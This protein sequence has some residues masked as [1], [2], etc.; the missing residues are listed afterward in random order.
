MVIFI[1]AHVP[2]VAL[3]AWARGNNLLIPVALSFALSGAVLL[4]W[5]ANRQALSTRLTIAA[6]LIGQVSLLVYG[7]AGHPW[8]ADMHMYYFAA[9]AVLAVFCDGRVVVMGATVTALHHLILNFVFPAAV[10]SGGSDLARVLLHAVL[11]VMETGAL[12]WLCL[13][14]GKAVALSS[15][16]LKTLE[17]KTQAEAAQADRLREQEEAQ[18]TKLRTQRLALAE[19]FEA[20]IGQVTRRLADS[21]TVMQKSATTLA[22]A[23]SQVADAS[24]DVTQSSR[25]ANDGALAAA[26]AT[27]QLHQ[28]INE[29]GSKI[30]ATAG[31]AQ[32]AVL[33]AEK[34]GERVQHLA[35]AADRIGQVI[36]LIQDIAA[37]TNLLAL[38]ATI[39]A[40]RA[41]DAGK[42]FAV[43]AAEV[44]QL[45]TQTARATE[46]IQTQVTA[47]Q[48]ETDQAVEAIV[49]IGEAITDI[50]GLAGSVAAAVHQQDSV[51]GDLAGRVRIVA[52]E[53]TAASGA[54]GTISGDT[55]AAQQVADT[56]LGVAK[57]L[58]EQSDQ[59]R[60][61]V[62][63]FL[64]DVRAD[65]NAA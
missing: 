20:R 60:G 41:G 25:I 53:M 14:L 63:S 64:S 2:V 55:R 12:A 32:E 10:F 57:M 9:I 44:K 17:E 42:G 45:A 48:S 1:A 7:L 49:K 54:L 3:L 65:A 39:E 31:A 61:D 43:V 38:N 62:D 15:N 5:F 50:N 27:Q 40:A 30:D 8:Q 11:V 36:R 29:I 46:D 16:T 37:Q 24:Q 35:E 13:M 52:K 6:A 4:A 51:T 58:A 19:R 23:V 47:I 28:S 59:L 26:S 34:T 22:T 18:E 56:L 21:V 33:S